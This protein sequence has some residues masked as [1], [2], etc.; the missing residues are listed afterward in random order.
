MNDVLE[1]FNCLVVN[2]GQREG[3][4]CFTHAGIGVITDFD[5]TDAQSDALVAFH[6]PIDITTLF[7]REER[8]TASVEHLLMKQVL[9]YIEVYGLWTPGLFD[10][11]V[12]TGQ[13]VSMRFVAGISI[14]A[15]EVLVRSLL[16]ANAPVKDATQVKRI[17][18]QYGLTFDINRVANNELRVIL[19]NDT[20]NS[21][22]NGDDAV[23]FLCYEATGEVLLIKSPEV[24]A[25]VKKVPWLPNFFELHDLPLAQVFNRHKR[26][27]LAAK[28]KT[29]ARAINRIS[30]MSK[31]QH[32]PVRESIAKTFVRHALTHPTFSGAPALSVVSTRDKL[33][34]LNLLAQR[35]VQANTASFKIRNGKVFTRGDRPVYALADIHRV[36]RMVLESLSAD[37]AHLKGQTILLDPNVD[38]GLPVSRKQTVGN[39][40]FGTLV[41]S[42]SNEISSGMYWE[43]EW[44]ATDLDL[45]TIDLDGNRVGWGGRSGFDH[46]SITFSGDLTDA[47]NGAM[48]FMTSRDRDYGLFVNIYSGKPGSKMELIV[49]A[50]RAKR[51]WIEKTLIREKHTLSS[52]D[53]VIGFVRGKTFVVWAGR[54]GNDRVSGI[55]PIV[56]ESRAHLWTLQRLFSVFGVKFDVDRDAETEYDHDLNYGSFSFD[57]LEALFK[58]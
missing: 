20:L 17:V 12:T 56:N 9:H 21:F 28:N 22:S 15:L 10:L 23:R 39:L 5:P 29:T 40:P 33:K 26:L 52:R 58:S 36:E 42:Y 48:E 50:S 32:V 27:I 4:T 51:Q 49:G 35:R 19:W 34:Y 24:I 43:N 41:T 8:D 3:Q 47:R 38:Y 18:E 13:L 31:A 46:G 25:A 1:L 16:Y 11:E 7:T 57:K 37:L 6:Q 2:D 54:L 30:R 14:G 44:G 55:N 53:S 45:S